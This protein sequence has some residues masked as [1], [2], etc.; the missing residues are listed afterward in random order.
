MSGFEFPL[1]PAIQAAKAL[2]KR[3]PG[4]IGLGT[5]MVELGYPFTQ[6]ANFPG[7]AEKR[8]SRGQAMRDTIR[9]NPQAVGTSLDGGPTT[10]DLIGRALNWTQDPY[11]IKPANAAPAAAPRDPSADGLPAPP[12]GASM[13]KPQSAYPAVDPMADHNFAS[14]GNPY[15]QG[16]DPMSAASYYPTRAPQRTPMPMARPAEATQAPQAPPDTSFFMRNALMMQDPN[17]GGFIDPTGAASV[18]GPDLIQKMMGYL[19]N[20]V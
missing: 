17:G 11:G 3:V 16:S 5:S 10:T 18:S 6:D 20:K 14:P 8:R 19:H 4:P 9:N 7:V 2:F 15:P 12:A 13:P 1:S